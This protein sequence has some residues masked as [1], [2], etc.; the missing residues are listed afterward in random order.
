MHCTLQHQHRS[1]NTALI[2]V[3]PGPWRIQCIVSKQT[4]AP[5]MST[6]L[7]H[8]CMAPHDARA[9]AQAEM[10]TAVLYHHVRTT[11]QSFT[12]G[13][14]SKNKPANLS[15]CNCCDVVCCA[16]GCTTCQ[17]ML[18]SIQSSLDPA[19]A[20]LSLCGHPAAAK[21]AACSS[22]TGAPPA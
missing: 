8:S 11:I 3:C 20:V 22:C 6:Q 5:S 12:L 2:M 13:A 10:T 21:H 9:G 19:T 15:S 4:C 17:H 16:V 14:A 18:A 1:R 7:Q